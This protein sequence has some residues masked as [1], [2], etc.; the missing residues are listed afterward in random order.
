MVR[1]NPASRIMVIQ[2]LAAL[3]QRLRGTAGGTR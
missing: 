2:N 3:V 1:Q